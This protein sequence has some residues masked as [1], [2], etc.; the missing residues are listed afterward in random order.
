MGAQPHS[1]QQGSSRSGPTAGGESGRDA[2]SQA[3]FRVCT[4][5]DFGVRQQQQDVSRRRAGQTTTACAMCRSRKVRCVEANVSVSQV[6]AAEPDERSRC[7]PC[8]QAGLDCQWN[9]VDRRKRR[10]VQHTTGEKAIDV[11]NSPGLGRARRVQRESHPPLHEEEPRLDAIN[12]HIEL[13]S[14]GRSK[15]IGPGAISQQPGAVTAAAAAAATP[16]RNLNNAGILPPGMDLAFDSGVGDTQGASSHPFLAGIYQYPDE[17]VPWTD[18]QDFVFGFDFMQDGEN[19]VTQAAAFSPTAAAQDGIVGG[20][21]PAS[22]TTAAAAAAK[23]RLIRLRYYR[24]FGPTAVMPGLRRLAL[25]VD[26]T[27]EDDGHHAH[28]NVCAVH[29]TAQDAAATAAA[30]IPQDHVHQRSDDISPTAPQ[31]AGFAP[32]PLVTPTPSSSSSSVA[33]LESKLF[34]RTSRKPHPDIV[35][36]VLDV[37]F[38]NFGGHFPFLHPQILGGHVRSQ[39]AS[40]FL[41]NAIAALTVRFCSLDGPLAALQDK[42]D[43]PWQRGAPFL[44]KAKEQLVP[45]LSIPAPEVVAGLLILAWAEF[46]DRNEAGMSRPFLSTFF[47]LACN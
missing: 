42:Y 6:A 23:S 31:A 46:G 8:R 15:N 14:D 12:S 4:V 34:D 24:R 30:G 17:T 35:C 44:V 22:P 29:D 16:S 40:S 33:S 39:E 5:D 38:D 13:G 28:G 21:G 26:S 18:L 11:S 41:L 19:F 45:L 10:K 7:L 47:L 43:V 32:S 36:Q 37:F 2:R 20:G 25:V 9:T 27:E 1:D 3:P